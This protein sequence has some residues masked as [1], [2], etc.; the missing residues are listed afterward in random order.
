ELGLRGYA[1]TSGA[2]GIHIQVPLEPRYGY[3]DAR[4]LAEIVA[5]V[6]TERR[7][8]LATTV[9][10]VAKRP[11]DRVYVDYLQNVIGKTIV[12]PYSVR[13][14]PRAPVSAPLRWS[15]VRK[16]LRPERFHMKNL[17]ARLAKGGDLWRHV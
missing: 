2:T 13:G 17:A 9:R 15:E 12:G 7:P 14:R 16:G 4:V 3:D 5:G 11:R 1:K 10:A 6:A 8:D